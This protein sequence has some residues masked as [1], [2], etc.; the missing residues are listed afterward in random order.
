MTHNVTFTTMTTALSGFAG[1]VLA[2]LVFGPKAEARTP[3]T[4]V[5]NCPVLTEN[6]E[7]SD[8]C[9]VTQDG[10]GGYIIDTQN[11]GQFYINQTADEFYLNGPKM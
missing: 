5:T 6:F 9:H 11:N 4:L 8:R 3:I 10:G 7:G 2:T 1:A